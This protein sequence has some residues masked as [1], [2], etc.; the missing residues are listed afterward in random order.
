MNTFK[1]ITLALM[2]IIF[3]VTG[4][5]AEEVSLEQLIQLNKE[6]QQANNIADYPT[7]LE[8]YE[9]GLN[10]SRQAKNQQG[11]AIFLGNIS[12]VYKNLGQYQKALTHYQQVL[13]VLSNGSNSVFRGKI[14]VYPIL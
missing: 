3:S 2:L 5:R 7:A 1:T 12:V 11:I 8:K 4:L 6:G 14:N 13:E 9:Q 10:L